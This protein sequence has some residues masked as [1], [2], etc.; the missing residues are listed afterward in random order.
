MIL[1]AR[2]VDQSA[3]EPQVCADHRVC[4]AAGDRVPVYVTARQRHGVRNRGGHGLDVA[5]RDESA[6]LRGNDFGNATAREGHNG[7]PAGHGLC[8]NQSI[9]F[10]PRGGDERGCRSAD[11]PGQLTV[12]QVSGV[13]HLVVETGHDEAFEVVAVTDRTG[14]YQ[15][16]ACLAGGRDRQVGCLLAGDASEPDQTASTGT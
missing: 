2:V 13:S 8:N 6:A 4:R 5:R 7:G 10:V 11:Q 15:G 9:R 14:Q 3:V 1:L 16:Q 12:I